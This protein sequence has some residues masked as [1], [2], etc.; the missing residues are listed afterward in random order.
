MSW[1][2]KAIEAHEQDIA[3][4]QVDRRGSLLELW[5]QERS[6][7]SA[8]R[9]LDLATELIDGGNANEVELGFYVIFDLCLADAAMLSDLRDLG[10]HRSA[11]VRRALAFFLSRELPRDYCA[12]LYGKLLRDKAASVRTRTIKS[13]GMHSFRELLPD[14][15]ALHKAEQN[16]KVLATLEYWIPL[17]DDGYRVEAS[18]DPT[19]LTVTALTDRGIASRTVAT[20][21]PEDRRIRDA[22]TELR[23][24]P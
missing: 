8:K 15:R 21:D 10:N 17:L 23:N 13:I 7:D 2:K 12:E 14:L 19:R 20:S 22:I 16:L 3:K 24:I 5:R 6:L 9:V 1:I 4:C 11:K 18:S